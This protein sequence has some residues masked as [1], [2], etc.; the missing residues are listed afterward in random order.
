MKFIDEAKIFIKSGDGGDGCLSFRRE[1]YIEFGGPDGGNGGKGGDIVIEGTKSLNT[2]VDYRFQKHFKAQKGRGGAGRN[3][4]GAAGKDMIL[5]IPVGTEILQDDEILADIVNDEK[6]ILFPGGEGGKG[7]INFKSSTNRAPRKTT[8]GE[9][10]YEAE[11]VL[12]LK[13]LADA[14]LVGFP[15]AGKSSLLRKISAAKPKVADY[16]FTTLDPKLGVVRKG[17]EEI[18]VADI[19][20]L[21]ED[22]HVGSGLGFKF[23]KHIERCHSLIHVIDITNEDLV[24]S[25]NTIINELKSYDEDLVNKNKIIVLNKCDLLKKEEIDKIRIDFENF[26]NLKIHLISTISGEGID[27][28]INEILKLKNI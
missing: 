20:G 25:Y 19:P 27:Q 7:N 9:K 11:V 14:G 5:K 21:I 16:P 10:G 12:R 22:A 15:N 18:V 4:T 6:M 26:I 8:P 24:K 13:I 28:L 1:K 2:L 23:L 17:D 3:R